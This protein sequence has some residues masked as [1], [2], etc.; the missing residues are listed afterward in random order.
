M[1]KKEKTF[2]TMKWIRS[3]RDEM[4]DKYYKGDLTEYSKAI[5]TPAK[6]KEDKLSPREAIPQKRKTSNS[7]VK[8]FDAVKWVREVRNKMYEESKHLSKEKIMV[9]DKQVRYN[10]KK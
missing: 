2:D 1:N 10:K 8:S 3:V 4:F 7:R 6:N 9:K 5:S